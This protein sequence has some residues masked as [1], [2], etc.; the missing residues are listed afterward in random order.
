MSQSEDDMSVRIRINEKLNAWFKEKIG[1]SNLTYSDV[2]VN[3]IGL[4]DSYRY[5]VYGRIE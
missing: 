1:D 3:E 5:K 2:I 4:D